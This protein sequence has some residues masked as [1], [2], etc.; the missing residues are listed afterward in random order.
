MNCPKCGWTCT[1]VVDSRDNDE[2]GTVY[3]RRKCAMCGYRYTTYELTLGQIEKVSDK[4]E[5]IEGKI[6]ARKLVK[7]IQKDTVGTKLARI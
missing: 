4:I 5:L 3:R 6:T 1:R 7:Y 2:S